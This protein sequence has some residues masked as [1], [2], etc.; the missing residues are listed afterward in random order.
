[1]RKIL[2]AATFLSITFIL[3]SGNRQIS[4]TLIDGGGSEA[5]AP[6][7]RYAVIAWNDLGMHCMDHDYSVFAILPP[8]NN[9]HAQL[10][11]RLTGK[12]VTSC[13]TLTYQAVTDT[14][15]SINTTSKGKT[16][17]WDWVYSLFGAQVKVNM[18]L[19]GNPTQ[20]LKPAAMTYDKAG[21]FWKAEGI[22]TVPYDDKGNA[23]YYSMV[24]VVTKDRNGS[25]LAT[26]RTVLPV[27]D[28]L[29]CSH[30]HASGTGDPMAQP[31]PDWVYDPDPDKDWKRNIL[32]LHDNKNLSKPIYTEALAQNGYASSGL[33]PTADSGH[34]VL[35]ANCHPSNAL[36]KQGI[37]GIKQLTTSM[38][39]WHAV[40]AM[41][42][43]TG[44][45]LDNT[46][47]RTGCYYCHPGSTTQ[48]LRGIMGSAKKPDGTSALECQ[49]CHGR[50]SKVG[51]PERAGW[52]DLPKCQ[53][54]HYRSA[55]GKYVRDTSAFDSSG[56]FRQ[57]TSIFS[58][59]GGLYKASATHGNMQCELC[60]GSTHAEYATS[61]AND[62]V[63]STWLQGYS[64]MTAECTVCHLNGLPITSKRGPH[65]LHTIGALWFNT[66]FMTARNNTRDCV[67]CHGTDYKGTMLSK[68]FTARSFSFGP[69]KKE[70]VQGQMVSCY[71]CHNGPGGK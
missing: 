44:M 32:L 25:I 43:N 66:H 71:D 50:M 65:G 59:G 60:H 52:V 33:M 8:Y 67:V 3:G 42:D 18:G 62:N 41:D 61:E 12:Q 54:C 11:D 14:R 49:S 29:A 22:P 19:A 40:N 15:G 48:C 68:T 13:I 21:G 1:M 51:S 27:S 55:D 2:L 24:K 53:N 7:G 70:Y 6:A 58:T 69:I 5:K 45:P 36:G 47:D 39:S 9:L 10:I 26:T 38:H 56:N 30:C 20:S 46:M 17:F 57:A 31:S 28:E 23:N 37:Q 64:G 4:A 16:N 35:C 63:Q 34:P